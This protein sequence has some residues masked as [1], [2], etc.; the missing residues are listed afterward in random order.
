MSGTVYALLVGINDYGGNPSPLRGCVRRRRGPGRGAAGPCR[1]RCAAARDAPRP[2]RHAP[3]D[4]R[5]LSS[6]TSAEA[7]PGD[8]ALF[9]FSGHGSYEPV[10][11]RFW[12]LE[13]TG[14]NQTIVCADSRNKRA[15]D[16]ADKEL[17]ELI[18]DVADKG[19]HVVVVLDCC[20]SG[21]GTRDPA[22]LPADVGVRHGSAGRRGA[23]RR[24][25]P[26]RRP[27]G[28]RSRRRRSASGRPPPRPARRP[29]GVR[30]RSALQGGARRRRLP[31]RVLDRPRTGPDDDAGER[32]LP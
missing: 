14:Q 10:E 15:G 17:N 27:R 13:P 23:A 19:P 18:A 12:F 11:E 8:V 2:G 28:R 30:T 16:L 4:H 26:P 3:A 24:A 7:G 29:V 1:A 20:H 9:A 21:G 6:R 32:H 31:R 25:L 22:G 5:R